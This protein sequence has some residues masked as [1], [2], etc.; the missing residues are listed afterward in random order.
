[1]EAQSSAPRPLEGKLLQL[2]F[3]RMRD[4]EALLNR[5]PQADLALISKQTR[6]NV[7]E[8][9]L[10]GLIE[11]NRRKQALYVGK[12]Y[13][14]A[15]T[16]PR[17]LAAWIE[18]HFKTHDTFCLLGECLTPNELHWFIWHLKR[19]IEMGVWEELDAPRPVDKVDRALTRIGVS[20]DVSW[21][22]NFPFNRE[23]QEILSLAGEDWIIVV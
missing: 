19:T 11:R 2:I 12:G 4:E 16:G 6:H 10:A 8:G 5:L 15:L 7:P 17:K 3:S 13:L 20:A 21:L 9:Y 14:A 1:M 22:S 23:E 18:L